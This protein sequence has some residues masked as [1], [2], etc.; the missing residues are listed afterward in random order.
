MRIKIHCPKCNHE[1]TIETIERK[2]EPVKPNKHKSQDD[3]V[4]YLRKM[5]GMSDA[6]PD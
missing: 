6:D 3:T 5:F 1:F 4:D 2:G